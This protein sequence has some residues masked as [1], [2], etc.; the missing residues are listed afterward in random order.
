MKIKKRIWDVFRILIGISILSLLILKLGVAE[1]VDVI[2]NMNLYIVF[3]VIISLLFTIFLFGVIFYPFGLFAMFLGQHPWIVTI[4]TCFPFYLLPWTAGIAIM[5]DISKPSERAKAVGL[6]F[7]SFS[8]AQAIGTMLGGIIADILGLQSLI[9]L[10]I[11][12][13]IGAFLF[14]Y[15]YL[16]E[17]LKIQETPQ[18]LPAIP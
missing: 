17:S 14:S 7:A 16:K 12:T 3:L 13:G 15:F 5:A 2:S 4:I 9:L 1:V 6:F 11:P 10:P 18:S 8:L